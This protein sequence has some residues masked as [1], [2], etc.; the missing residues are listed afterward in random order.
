MSS[1][2]RTL[3]PVGAND[4]ASRDGRYKWVVL[5]NT[6]I[7]TLMATIDAS[8]V[9]IS[10]PAI[11]RGINM[12]PLTTSNTSYLLWMLMGYM[13]VTA[14]LVVS[15]GR[16]GDMFGRVKMYNL[17]FAIF[18]LG[19]L[20]AS[21]TY[22]DGPPA[23]IYLIAMRLV[24]G[25]GGA[26]LMAN[27]AAILTDA[28]PS[29]QRGMALGINSVAGIAGT[30]VGLVAGGLLAVVDWHLI[31]YVSVPIGLA[32]TV[33]GYLKL[34]EVA[35]SEGGR[36]DIPG[37]LLFGVG[38]IAVLVGIT[39]ALQPY[40]GTLMLVVFVIV[41]LRS[42]EPMFDMRL[43]KLR[44]F[45]AGN[46]ASL[47]GAIGRGGL[48]FMLIIWLQ[49]IWLPLHGY[50]FEDTPLWAG[51]YMLPLTAG[52]LIAGPVS[53]V[54]SDRF[55]ARPFATGGMLAAAL[56]FGLLMVLPVN[57]S[58]VWF[59]LLLLGN[60]LAMGLF[61][62]PNTAGIMN[63]VPANRRG[64]A[65]GMR[66]TFQN[67][68]MTL[69][70][71]LFFS[72]MVA[73]LSASLHASLSSGLTAAGLPA[74]AAAKVAGLPPVSVLFA[75]FLGYNPLKTLL[76][77]TLTALPPARQAALTGHT[78]FPSLISG[79]FHHGLAIVFTFGLLVCLM[80]AAASWL[81]GASGTRA[82]SVARVAEGVADA[83]RAG[84][85]ATVEAAR[86]E[87]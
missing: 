83:A 3:A 52:F 77:P 79:P 82:A 86:R 59:A 28:F 62:A 64:V 56:T 84:A 78:F 24:Q 49:G 10:L 53:G 51:I 20:A 87:Q 46:L 68:G 34:Q 13:V 9:L 80:A 66:S 14:V 33:W 73:G 76:G 6:T 54:L 63:S 16:I 17:G 22:F 71:G 23:A 61:A 85:D 18:T 4:P 75:A 2:A 50:S 8:I 35:K 32:G 38:L 57:F 31:F 44:A 37:N 19:S 21:L 7:G 39:Y 40:G 36:L 70:I 47:G 81:R 29:D 60:G 74:A 12:N 55:G 11:F 48:M 41:E 1:G 72:I 58:Y 43:F 67:A 45:V 42:A 25:I 30:F 15:F 27:S 5:T 26:M 69:S 65:S